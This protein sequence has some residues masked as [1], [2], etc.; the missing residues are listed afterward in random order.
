MVTASSVHT[1]LCSLFRFYL[2]AWWYL[3]IFVFVLLFVVFWFLKHSILTM[4]M[5]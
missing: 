2:R 1:M 3:P 5:T 4:G